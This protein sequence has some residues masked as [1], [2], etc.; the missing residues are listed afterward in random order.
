MGARLDL[1]YGSARPAMYNRLIQYIATQT[2]FQAYSFPHAEQFRFTSTCSS[3]EIPLIGKSR[4][5][6]TRPPGGNG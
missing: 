6:Y 3:A 1:N 4:M 2:W 5:K